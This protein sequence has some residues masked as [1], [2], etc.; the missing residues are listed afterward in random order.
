M[1]SFPEEPNTQTNFSELRKGS[2]RRLKMGHLER[3]WSTE[4]VMSAVQNTEQPPR[5]WSWTLGV[6]VEGMG[7]GKE[8]GEEGGREEGG[9]LREERE[10]KEPLEV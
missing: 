10:G 4:C 6:V 2:S 8:R 1:A 5:I 7:G 3:D 9:S